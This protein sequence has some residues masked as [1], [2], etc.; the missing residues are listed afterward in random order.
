MVS[1]LGLVLSGG[2][3]RGLA[4]LGLIKV[5]EENDIE[6]TAVSGT[7]A[8]SIIAAFYAQGY[9]TDD[10][11]NIVLGINT[12]KFLKPALS[13]KGLLKMDTLYKEL[14][15]YFDVNEFAALKIPVAIAAT[16]L[17]SGSTEYF[18]KGDLVG[19]IC[20]SS[21]IP[22]LFDPYSYNGQLYID[23][24]IL[25]NL[26]VQPLVGKAKAIL[27]SHCNP[28]DRDFKPSNARLVMERA[29][30]LSIMQNS[31][32]DKL[33]CD[34]FFEPKGLEKFKVMDFK[35]AK[36]IYEIG[37]QQAQEKLALLGLIK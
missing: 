13:L 14:L 2:G 32:R 37:Y 21:C 9:S 3:I 34:F 33:K 5:L 1:Q 27:G 24:G 23:G 19:A 15:P 7:S 8:G 22:V 6:I 12:F 18:E 20:A 25:N 11:L 28:T 16:N 26:P 36:E 17:R 31:Y 35:N 30:N 4:H 29:L 10:I